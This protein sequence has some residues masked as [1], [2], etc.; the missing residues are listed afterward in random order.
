MTTL[1]KGAIAENYFK[2]GL[3]CS[4]AV[5]MAFAEDYRID[6]ELAK[7]LSIGFGG[8]M[9]R[10]REVCG[11]VAGAFMVFGLVYG[12]TKTKQEIYDLE[13]AFA[14]EFKLDNGSYI[15]KEL[16]TLKK[17][18]C[19]KLVEYTADLLVKYIKK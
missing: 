8:G 13:Q 10:L 15:C 4:Q 14:Q 16:L 1:S 17:R 11:A 6:I 5:F 7:K 12:D 2:S 19:N 9:G 18:P 3:N